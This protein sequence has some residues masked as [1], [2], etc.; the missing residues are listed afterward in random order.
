M[1]IVIMILGI[2][3]IIIQFISRKMQENEKSQYIVVAQYVVMLLIVLLGAY[4]QIV[5]SAKDKEYRQAKLEIEVLCKVS[6]HYQSAMKNTIRLQNN[7]LSIKNYLSF[8]KSKK[9][10][11]EFSDLINWQKVA[12]E[13]HISE[14]NAGKAAFQAIQ[15][16]AAN[17]LRL[18]I[19]Y[20]GILP[21]ETV[22]WANTTLKVRFND[23]ETYFDPFSPIG[24]KPKASVLEYIKSTGEAF[25]V[26][27]GR[28]RNA[29][30]V[31]KTI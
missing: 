11:R 22:A 29:V 3:G 15:S 26:V 30:N 21:A 23:I 24:C 14:L 12:S 4:S 17:I 16:I 28:I 1:T 7:F 19:E 9:D 13:K 18:S 31:I 20:E 6:K 10:N 5:T 25:G 8:E 27:I 2:I